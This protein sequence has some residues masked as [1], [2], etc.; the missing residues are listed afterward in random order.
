[1]GS[2]VDAGSFKGEYGELFE[3][4]TNGLRIIGIDKEPELYFLV[5][6]H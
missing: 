4:V 6:Y 1:M 2:G 5:N 3:K